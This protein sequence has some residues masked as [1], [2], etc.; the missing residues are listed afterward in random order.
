MV[1]S[2]TLMNYSDWEIPFTVHTYSSDKQL[3]T[4][5]SQDNKPIYLLFRILVK[6]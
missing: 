3:G 1:S 5:I 6:P 2:E 4:V